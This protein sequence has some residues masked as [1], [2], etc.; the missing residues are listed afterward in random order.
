M[1]VKQCPDCEGDVESVSNG[2]YCPSCRD[3][4]DEG[5]V[6]QIIKWETIDFPVWVSIEHYGDNHKFLRG[7]QRQTDINA[8]EIPEYVDGMKYCVFTVW[9]KVEKD[10]S[11]NG[12]Y[13]EKGGEKT[14]YE[15]D[16]L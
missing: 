5:E 2:W 12:P 16:S 6:L 3:G 1:T 4:W 9:F 10:G 15:T 11:I 13:G 8:D 14:I 7:F